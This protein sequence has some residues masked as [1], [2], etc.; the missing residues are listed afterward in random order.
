MVANGNSGASKLAPSRITPAEDMAA[1]DVLGP[2]T[3]QAIGYA[4]FPWS[5]AL[6]LRKMRE[7][8]W[9]PVDDDTFDYQM[10][11]ELCRIDYAQ[12]NPETRDRPRMVVRH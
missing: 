2:L 10:A 6:V 7:R 3:K 11:A 5:P 4:V 8:D 1:F 9:V 12:Q